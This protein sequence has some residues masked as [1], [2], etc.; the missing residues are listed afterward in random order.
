MILPRSSSMPLF[1][2]SAPLT[3]AVASESFEELRSAELEAS[4][5]THGE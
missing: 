1:S 2:W 4:K 3:D 5:D